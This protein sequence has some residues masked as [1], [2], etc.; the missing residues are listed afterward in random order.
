MMPRMDGIKAC[1]LLKADR[2]F[3]RIPLI[4]TTAMAEQSTE[5]TVLQA[6]ADALIHKPLVMERLLKEV[7]KRIGDPSPGDPQ[8]PAP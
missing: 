7:R 1:A 2:R 6:G 3:A 5:A 4:I 8:A